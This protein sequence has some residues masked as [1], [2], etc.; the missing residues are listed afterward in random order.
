MCDVVLAVGFSKWACG[1]P[2]VVFSSGACETAL[3]V[4]PCETLRVAGFSSD[5]CET[6]LAV[7]PC[8]TLRVTGFSSDAC[9][10]ALPVGPCETLRVV[11]FS[12]GTCAGEATLG[13]GAD[14]EETDKGVGVGAGGAGVDV[15][16]MVEMTEAEWDRGRTGAE[17]WWFSAGSDGTSAGRSRLCRRCCS[18]STST[19]NRCLGSFC[20]VAVVPFSSLALAAALA[21]ASC[22]TAKREAGSEH[23]EAFDLVKS[24][25]CTSMSPLSK[26]SCD[27]Y[28]LASSL[29][30]LR[31]FSNCFTLARSSFTYG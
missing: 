17:F 8:E 3:A 25:P 30:C 15:V 31:A 28:R 4:G 18:P 19:L 21:R 12:S 16:G 24:K 27:L 22:R 7:G 13:V 10:P 29:S 2:A 11:G 5:A 1:A 9:E 14:D 20:S 23:G 6:A 26:S